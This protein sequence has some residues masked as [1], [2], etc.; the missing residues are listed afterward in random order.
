ME[1]FLTPRKDIEKTYTYEELSKEV[2]L[3]LGIDLPVSF[4]EFIVLDKEYII[5]ICS[6]YIMDKD[7]KKSN[8]A[9][10]INKYFNEHKL[11]ASHKNEIN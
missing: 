3:V 9:S 8:L 11:I 10:Y 2:S 5:N 4:G 1:N 6:K 7:Q